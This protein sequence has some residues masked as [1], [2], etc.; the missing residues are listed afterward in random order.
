MEARPPA[1]YIPKNP[2][3]NVPFYRLEQLLPACFLE[4]NCLRYTVSHAPVIKGHVP[5]G[6]F[7][8]LTRRAV[9]CTFFLCFE[10]GN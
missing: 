8:I 1:T 5:V 7:L 4:L 2:S 9:E 3:L 6:C 10:P